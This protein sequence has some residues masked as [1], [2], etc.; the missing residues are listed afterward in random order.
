MK[1]AMPYI[2]SVLTALISMFVS[3]Y[4]CNRNCKNEINKIK[5]QYDKDIEKLQKQHE[6]DLETIK[7]QHQLE[8]EKILQMQAHEIDKQ[9]EET[10]LKTVS[11]I[12]ETLTTSVLNAPAVRDEINKQVN[13]SFLK[14]KK[15]R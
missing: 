6:N 15:R 11:G 10:A 2:I 3:I 12:T 1:D 9:R 13:N 8:M 5:V 14:K 4:V 7:L